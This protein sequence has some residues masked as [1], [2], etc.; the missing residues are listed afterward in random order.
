METSDHNGGPR[1]L[2]GGKNKEGQHFNGLG[3][4]TC[5]EKIGR[6]GEKGRKRGNSGRGNL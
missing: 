4:R 6:S 1:L 3:C 2:G 5:R